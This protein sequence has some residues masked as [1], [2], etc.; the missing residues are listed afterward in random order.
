MICLAGN[1]RYFIKSV[2]QVDLAIIIS[3][4]VGI[5]SIYFQLRTKTKKYLHFCCF[6]SLFLSM[7]R[8]D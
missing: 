8:V 3:N 1:P 5:V 6:L 7:A 2:E 4:R